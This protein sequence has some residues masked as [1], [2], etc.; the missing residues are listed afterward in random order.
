MSGVGKGSYSGGRPGSGNPGNLL[1]EADVA[2]L[3][4]VGVENVELLEFLTDDNLVELVDEGL[5]EASGVQRTLACA[6]L[7]LL[8][9]RVKSFSSHS[10]E[11]MPL[12]V[13]GQVVR[14]SSFND[15]QADKREF[16]ER[17]VHKIP[18][19]KWEGFTDPRP[20]SV[21]IHELLEVCNR[22]QF[23]QSEAL[24]FLLSSL[25][26]SVAREV[27]VHLSTLNS[28]LIV[29]EK[30]VS[31]ET[32]LRSSYGG[33][34]SLVRLQSRLESIKQSGREISVYIREVR[35]LIWE[36]GILKAPWGDEVIKHRFKLGLDSSYRSYCQ[37]FASDS[38]E[39]I[40]H[41]LREWEFAYVA[42]NQFRPNQ[43]RS[44]IPIT[45]NAVATQPRRDFKRKPF[46]VCFQYQAGN[47]TFGERCKFSHNLTKNKGEITRAVGEVIENKTVVSDSKTES[48]G[49]KLDGVS[50]SLAQVS[51]MA[52]AKVFT[53][54]DLGKIETNGMSGD[55]TLH[56][57]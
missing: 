4:Q 14:K 20:L 28:N 11:V 16:R 5:A 42:D 48:I 34:D 27:N 18:F 1:S 9:Q 45:A 2:V 22:E 17:D 43:K 37:L 25:E 44:V 32:F 53:D 39:A 3:Q 23:T 57:S 29:H 41:R 15:L 56:I 8:R 40:C 47:C 46:G 38:F 26:Q 36:A 21:F 19:T 35:S 52:S 7:K 49:V 30:L 10:V 54:S 31:V 24:R 13:E 50:V 12:K 55:D 33:T 51:G 6:Q